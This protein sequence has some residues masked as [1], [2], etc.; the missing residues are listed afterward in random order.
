MVDYIRPV[1]FGE[2]MPKVARSLV[3]LLSALTLGGLMYFNF[4]DIGV[5][6]AVRKFW[7]IKH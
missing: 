5:V 3:Y 4:N 7:A 2:V 1:L 6:E